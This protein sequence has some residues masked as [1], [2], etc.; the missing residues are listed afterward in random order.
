MEGREDIQRKLFF[1]QGVEGR[2]GKPGDAYP[3]QESGEGDHGRFADELADQ[4]T[5]FCTHYFPYAYF[6]GATFRPGCGEV[7]EIDTGNEQ[8]DPGYAG[9]ESHI[10]NATTVILFSIGKMVIEIPI[11]HRKKK[12]LCFY[13]LHFG[14]QE[15]A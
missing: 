9:E 14:A 6:F 3:Q 15:I 1:N 7:H 8:D 11:V 2:K 10:L 12:A 4:A 5:S 13:S